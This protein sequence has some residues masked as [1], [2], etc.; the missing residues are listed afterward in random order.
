MRPYSVMVERRDLT[1]YQAVEQGE[2]VT[3]PDARAEVGAPYATTVAD[4][5]ASVGQRVERGDVLLEVTPPGNSI[6]KS[7]YEAARTAVKTAEAALATAR[8]PYDEAVNQARAILE[9]A[10]K[11]VRQAR[12]I[13]APT[14]GASTAAPAVTIAEVPAIPAELIAAQQNALAALEQ[15]KSQRDTAIAS[16]QQAVEQARAELSRFEQERKG[17]LVRAPIAGTV[18][19]LNARTGQVLESGEADSGDPSRQ[20]PVVATIVD[21]ERLQ[22]HLPLRTADENKDYPVQTGAPVRLAF[23]GLPGVSFEGTVKQIV[24]ADAISSPLKR[25]LKSPERIA[26]VTFTN[27]K[28]QVK[29]DSRLESASIKR[30]EVKNAIVV[31]TKAIDRDRNGLTTVRVQRNGQWESVVVETGLSDG[32]YTAIRSGLKPGEA[33]RVTQDL[34]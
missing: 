10:R 19:A 29:P 3:P 2:V 28:G 25:A 4:V 6:A 23:R 15:A 26:L 30:G 12:Q 13:A 18:L 34:L 21:L 20:Q 17:G 7:E 33:V 16:Y 1:A 14:P 8:K 24:S 5:Y 27:Q 22:V 9:Q 31:P 32:K 11:A